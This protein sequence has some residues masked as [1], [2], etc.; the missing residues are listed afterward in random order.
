MPDLLQLLLE[1]PAQLGVVIEFFTR[2]QAHQHRQRGFQG[3]AKIAQGIARALEAVLGVRQQMVDLRHQRLQ[4]YRDL[5]VQLR[6]LPLLQLGDLLAGLFQGTQRPTYGNPLQH[7]NQ[8]Q[9]RQ[10]QPEA[11]LLH[12]QETVANRGVV[13]RHADGNRLSQPPIVGTQHQQLL[14][15]GP[16]LQVAVQP[17]LSEAGKLLVPQGSR[18]PMFVGE[19]DAEVVP[20][21]RPLIGRR[22]VPLIQLQTLRPA[23]QCHQQVLAVVA[24]ARLEV[25]LQTHFE[26]PQAGLRQHQ[27]DNHHHADQAQAQAALD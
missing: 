8:Q 26:Q 5:I 15:L 6:A 25:A 18:A 11:D 3:V 27:T 22:Q 21:E 1:D 24:Q 13:L 12:A 16:Q 9:P 2:G 19:I 14:A 10:S 7:Q 17:R 23:Y 20:G 4:L